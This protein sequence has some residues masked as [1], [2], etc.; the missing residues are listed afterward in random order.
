MP[1]I[2]ASR[3]HVST[4][5]YRH[6]LTIRMRAERLLSILMALQRGHPL[7]AG[8]LAQRLEVSIRTIFRDID[9]LSSMGVPVYSEPGR[10]GGIRLVE[11]YTSDLTG[12]SPGEAEAL[13]L[14]ASPASMGRARARDAD[15]VRRSTSSRPRC[16]RCINCAHSTRAA[17]CCSTRSPGSARCDA[18][19][20]LDQLRT[21]HLEGRLRRHPLRAQ[22]RRASRL[23]RRAV[24]AGREGRHLVPDRARPARDARVP[25][26]AH[27]DAHAD[28]RDVR[29]RCGL[30]SAEV[31]EALVRAFRD[32]P[33]A[34]QLRRRAEDHRARAPRTCWTR[35]ARGSAARSSR[36]A[37]ASAAASR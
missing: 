32:Q 23:P 37:T 21:L 5:K 28:R 15:A 8:E 25:H 24:R 29:A 1:L 34:A 35:S 10:G 11:G 17:G 2:H 26:L 14:I 18:S 4:V 22:Q 30:R 33:A 20:F 31:L 3:C 36:S 16:R 13:A 27:P 9:A 19:P 12:L 6:A 7:T